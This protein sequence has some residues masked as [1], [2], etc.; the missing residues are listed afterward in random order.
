MRNL[1]TTECFSLLNEGDKTK[2][3]LNLGTKY[4]SFGIKTWSLKKKGKTVGHVRGLLLE[5]CQFTVQPSGNRKVIETGKKDVH[6]FV[7]GT[8]KTIWTED[9]VPAWKGLEVKYNPHKG[10]RSFCS[11]EPSEVGNFFCGEELDFTK[12]IFEAKKVFLDSDW[13]VY[14]LEQ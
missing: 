6:A 5:D 7:S 3:H 9:D 8:I 10:M 1:H 11:Y 12:P 2:A 4:R 14:V 13:K